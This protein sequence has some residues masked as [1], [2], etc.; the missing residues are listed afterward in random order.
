M[1]ISFLNFLPLETSRLRIRQYQGTDLEPTRR[2]SQ[3]PELRKWLLSG[4]YSDKEHEEYVKVS[5]TSDT[6]DFVVE[7]KATGLVMGEMTFHRWEVQ[8]TWEM[9][10]LILPEFQGKGYASEAAK[11]LLKV[12]FEQMELHRIVAMAHPEN[13]ASWRLMEKIGMRK[14][15]AYLQSIP[16]PDST[17]WD[18]VSYAI[19]ASEYKAQTKNQ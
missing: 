3:D 1:T 9:G 13:S 18:G 6:K 14:E 17:W 16:R 4:V 8:R 15:G 5:S 10:W 12:G 11:S 7:E 2:M 19:L